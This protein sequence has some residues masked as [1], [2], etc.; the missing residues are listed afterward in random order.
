MFKYL[1]EL[2]YCFL[3]KL[4]RVQVVADFCVLTVMACCGN[5]LFNLVVFPVPS[6]EFI[7][8][9]LAMEA[10]S[11]PCCGKCLLGSLTLY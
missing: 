1:H 10:T 5:I 3:E 9:M 4:D 11:S 6:C 7:Y 8:F 2:S